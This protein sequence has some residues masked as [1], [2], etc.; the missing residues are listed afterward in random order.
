MTGIEVGRWNIIV[1][2]VSVVLMMNCVFV[3][4]SGEESVEEDETTTYFVKLVKSLFQTDGS[5]YHHVW[6]EMEF[7][8]KIIVGSFIGFC[9][10]AFGSVGG[11]GGGGM[12]M[13]A[14][15]STV[16]YNLKLRHP[17]LDMPI[18]DYDLALLIQPM[19]M[20]GI[21]LGVAF[22][23]IFADW[24]VTV[25]LIVLF[26]GTSSKAFFRGVETWKKETIMKK[27]AAKRLE[28]N[29]GAEAEY[30]ILPG[31]PSNGSS[32]KPERTLKEEV[33]IIENVCWKELGLL[34]FV[35]IA[36]LGLQIGK[37]PISLG[38]SGYEAVC[39]YKGTR[40]ISSMGD[41][42]SNL[43]IGQLVLY[44]SF[45]VLA[46]LVGG[47]LGLGGGFIM[48]PM[49][50]ELGVPPQVSSATATF[51]MTF[52]SSM[53]VVEYYLLKRF[54]VPYGGV[55][56]SDMIGK[57]ERHEYMGFEDLCKYEV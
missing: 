29:D 26:I 43:S 55:G 56:I 45:G 51:A 39:L 7:G 31:G 41:S 52:S 19:L 36:F 5:G 57:I 14:A 46:G 49:F 12:I 28:N 53:S 10:A 37:I 20:L 17:T 32:T 35:W 27:E 11:V 42:A 6:P 16:Y 50:L 9:G 23:V 21:S 54:P 18:I 4:V 22:N 38:V 48:G 15:A 1:R 3:F 44:C 34:V 30:K 40:S 47:L 24:M 13:G 25:L 8:W 2:F 33:P